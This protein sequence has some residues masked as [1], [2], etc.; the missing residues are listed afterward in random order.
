MFTTIFFISNIII[1]YIYIYIYIC[2]IIYC[3]TNIVV[4]YFHQPRAKKQSLQ[5]R[6]DCAARGLGPKVFRQALEKIGTYASHI[7]I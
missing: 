6:R 2:M 3:F 5:A 7:Y 1:I 4:T